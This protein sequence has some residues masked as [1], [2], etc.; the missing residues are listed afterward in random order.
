MVFG[1]SRQE[2]LVRYLLALLRTKP[3][4]AERIP[5]VWIVQH[6]QGPDPDRDASDA[7]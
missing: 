7:T 6:D 2:D 5:D 4:L 3:T 1:Q